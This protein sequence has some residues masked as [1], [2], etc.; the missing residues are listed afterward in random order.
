MFSRVR[1][2]AAPPPGEGDQDGGSTSSNQ[3]GGGGGW[4]S[5]IFGR[6]MVKVEEAISPRVVQP[7]EGSGSKSW[8]C[9]SGVISS[10]THFER[11][12]LNAMEERVLPPEIRLKIVFAQA[13]A[14]EEEEERLEADV[15]RLDGL[16]RTLAL[17]GILERNSMDS[18]TADK[19]TPDR[20]REL[21]KM[22]VAA[23]QLELFRMLDDICEAGDVE[24][25]LFDD[26]CADT[27]QD[28]RRSGFIFMTVELLL[29]PGSGYKRLLQLR[30]DQILEEIADVAGLRSLGGH[31]CQRSS[32][33][34][35]A[36]GSPSHGPRKR[37][38]AMD[39]DC[40]SP[41]SAAGG[42]GLQIAGGNRSA[43][44]NL[45]EKSPSP[46]SPRPDS[47]RSPSPEN[48]HRRTQTQR[49]RDLLSSIDGLVQESEEA[50]TGMPSLAPNGPH[51][52]GAAAGAGAGG[53]APSRSVRGFK[54][55]ST[56]A[57]DSRSGPSSRLSLRTPPPLD[58]EGGGSSHSDRAFFPN[59]RD[60]RGSR[61]GSATTPPP[62]L[63]AA[64]RASVVPAAPG[65]EEEDDP[66]SADML[67]AEVD[68]L[69][70]GTNAAL[71]VG[72]TKCLL[73]EAPDKRGAS[74]KTGGASESPEATLSGREGKEGVGGDLIGIDGLEITPDKRELSPKR[75]DAPES[76]DATRVAGETPMEEE[77][78]ASLPDEERSSGALGVVQK[79]LGEGSIGAEDSADEQ[80]AGSPLPSSE[81]ALTYSPSP[82]TRVSGSSP[83]SAEKTALVLLPPTEAGSLEVDDNGAGVVPDLDDGA[84]V[85]PLEGV[86][87]FGARGS[88]EGGEG[89]REQLADD[90][91]ATSCSDGVPAADSAPGDVSDDVKTGQEVEE[92]DKS[93]KPALDAVVEPSVASGVREEGEQDGGV[94]LGAGIE[95]GSLDPSQEEVGDIGRGEPAVLEADEEGLMPSEAA[96]VRQQGRVTVT[97]SSKGAAGT[98]SGSDADDSTRGLKESAAET[99]FSR[100]MGRGS[101]GD[102]PSPLVFEAEVE[103]VSA[104]EDTQ[105][106]VFSDHGPENGIGNGGQNG[107]QKGPLGSSS[108]QG[109][110]GSVV[111]A[112]G[113]GAEEETQVPVFEEIEL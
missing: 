49:V 7:S 62:E 105:S 86:P 12:S 58:G 1:T 73:E 31:D 24:N 102:G 11:I 63:A 74:P 16:V 108:E 66:A 36:R 17:Y 25:E 37:V 43:S 69:I 8:A 52:N 110:G 88:V 98:S 59:E 61:F 9:S 5:N 23:V 104:G 50:L 6:V 47:S 89:Q 3:G 35:S 34:S 85:M 82:E 41:G 84:G 78:E 55:Q 87:A 29:S 75:H 79:A 76:A 21:G 53:S 4:M 54:R 20:E 112:N 45:D 44:A 51:E 26:L 83:D 33:E 60:W 90:V 103:G 18:T 64:R 42:P 15:E 27:I 38:A 91:T 113:P 70:A 56:G 39:S 65:A 106:V 68:W 28:G 46:S 10:L 97:L 13:N 57:V 72:N 19:L 111:V 92:E 96:G 30:K 14:V 77:E 95:R 32:S 99:E 40:G 81:A 101:A 2:P 48:G 71:G 67:L 100:E 22:L 109:G 107:F 93:E 80:R 94:V